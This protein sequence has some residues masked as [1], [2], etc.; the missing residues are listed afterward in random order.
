MSDSAERN[1]SIDRPL[2]N[3][4]GTSAETD[5]G[6][7]S[8]APAPVD[9]RRRHLSVVLKLTL[10]VTLTLLLPLGFILSGS[11]KYWRKVIQAQ[12]DAQLSA[13]AA[14]RRD[15]VQAQIALLRQRVTINTDRGELRGFFYELSNGEP[16]ASNRD[17]S[18]MT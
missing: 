12:V 17:G 1:P 2:A 11:G 4:E 5:D 9:R 16:S 13:V 3:R 15:M 7:H 14:S 8:P 18:Q 6:A 10:L